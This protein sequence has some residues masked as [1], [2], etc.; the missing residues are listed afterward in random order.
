MAKIEGRW[1]ALLAV[2]GVVIYLNWLMLVPFLG[3]IA[4][5]SV[6]VILFWPAHRRIVTR[7]KNPTLSSLFSCLLVVFVILIPVTL[8][9]IAVVNEASKLGD[10]VQAMQSN[11]FDLLDRNSPLTGG[12][13]RFLEPYIDLGQLRASEAV[14][15]RLQGL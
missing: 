10:N 3:V 1:I 15:E 13:V 7:L 11:G 2:T 6:L 9:S 5:A 12:L 4:W 8:V 14:A